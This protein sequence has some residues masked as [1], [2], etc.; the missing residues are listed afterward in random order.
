MVSL[1]ARY[2]S[3]R[4]YRAGASGISTAA[5]LALLWL[6]EIGIVALAVWRVQFDWA[7]SNYPG[8]SRLFRS[9]EQF[10]VGN[11][12]IARISATRDEAAISQADS[13]MKF[14]RGGERRACASY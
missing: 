12:V 6:F 8:L 2:F 3:A 10:R 7:A 1:V 14:T 11:K 4:G 9:Y 5:C 13:G